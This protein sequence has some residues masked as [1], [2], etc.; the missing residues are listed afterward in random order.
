MLPQKIHLEPFTRSQVVW[1]NEKT[2]QIS[3]CMFCRNR[4]KYKLKTVEDL[5]LMLAV[6]FLESISL[7]FNFLVQS[8]KS[9]MHL[10]SVVN[11]SSSDT[12]YNRCS[13]AKQSEKYNWRLESVGPNKS[14]PCRQE[15]CDVANPFMYCDFRSFQKRNVLFTPLKY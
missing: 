3:V 10:F 5:V 9:S 15:R 1:F 8:L 12:F 13:I 11:C 4:T 7:F 2:N 6:S 14:I